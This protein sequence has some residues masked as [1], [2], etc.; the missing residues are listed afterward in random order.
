MYIAGTKSGTDAVQDLLIPLQMT[1]HT[2]RAKAAEMYYSL[3]SP[4]RVVGHSLGGAVALDLAE[5][6][7]IKVSTY[8]APIVSFRSSTERHRDYFDPVSLFDF[9]AY[10]RL[11]FPHSYKGY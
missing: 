9:G 7:G 11:S 1:R 4:T 8:G 6:H 5:D 3:Y 2:D 10:N